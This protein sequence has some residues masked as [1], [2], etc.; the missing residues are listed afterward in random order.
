MKL[1]VLQGYSNI[2]LAMCLSAL[3]MVGCSTAH[4][5]K[6][7]FSEFSGKETVIIY[8]S[9][10][11][12]DSVPGEIG[13]LKSAR[14]LFITKDSMNGWTIYPPLSTLEQQPKIPPFRE[15]PDEITELTQL[16]ALS[17]IGL[18]IEQLP[19]HFER[20]ENLDSLNLSMNK[21]TISK[22]LEKL[23]R[24]KN[25]KY[26]GIVGNRIETAD[27]QQ[28][29]EH[30]RDLVIDSGLGENDSAYAIQQLTVKDDLALFIPGKD[31]TQADRK[32]HQLIWELQ[33]V[34]ESAIYLKT[35]NVGV[36][37]MIEEQPNDE[38]PFF[39]VGVFE[40][41]HDHMVR[42][43]T[44]RVSLRNTIEKYDRETDTWLRLQ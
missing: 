19:P 3:L 26:L 21:L 30:N 12:L 34:R 9:K 18:D 37:T 38:F 39:T 31:C 42:L 16:K 4:E 43:D 7:L 40:F 14:N 13:Q 23:K 35:Q 41:M 32:I 17:L 28:L 15:L 1:N 8:L 44:Y 11:N 25:L 29:R 2:R 33:E 27:I 6:R 5:E 36:L 10:F 24:L 22:E 20:L